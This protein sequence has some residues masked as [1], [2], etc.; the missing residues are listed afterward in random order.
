ML[1]LKKNYLNQ[2][3]DDFIFLNR[4]IKNI[5]SL[6]YMKNITLG[7]NNITQIDNDIIYY[8]FKNL[9]SR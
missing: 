9:E 4:V 5:K 7:T 3:S 8:D 1:F 2:I 6:L